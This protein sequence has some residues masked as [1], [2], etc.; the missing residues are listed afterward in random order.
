MEENSE[1][2]RGKQ[3]EWHKDVKDEVYANEDHITAKAVG[4]LR[5]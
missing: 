2:L 5:T 1:E 3:V 4:R